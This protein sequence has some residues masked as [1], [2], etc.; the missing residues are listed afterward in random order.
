[1]IHWKFNELPITFKSTEA[2][3][4]RDISK[5]AHANHIDPSS[6]ITI[7]NIDGDTNKHLPTDD[8]GSNG[9]TS[10]VLQPTVPVGT[11]KVKAGKSETDVL[12]TVPGDVDNVNIEP[13][14]L[15]ILDSF[16]DTGESGNWL[17]S[18]PDGQDTH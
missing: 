16:G 1:M 18:E 8:L 4:I 14:L 3:L 11:K 13:E 2:N 7:F 10:T 17:D 12:P 5:M 15:D 6:E 9:D